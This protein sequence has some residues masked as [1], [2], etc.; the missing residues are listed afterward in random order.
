LS[1]PDR[2]HLHQFTLSS[3]HTHNLLAMLSPSDLHGLADIVA[4]LASLVDTLARWIDQINDFTG[5]NSQFVAEQ[6]LVLAQEQEEAAIA[7]VSH[8]S[9]K[10]PTPSNTKKN[11]LKAP[12]PP[13]KAPA[14]AQACAA[15]LKAHPTPSQPAP[16]NLAQTFPTVNPRVW[17][18]YMFQTT[19]IH[20][21]F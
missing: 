3:L 4:S 10:K 8:S 16:F 12:A 7:A 11:L 1:S 19:N 14:K 21:D 18:F 13:P 6:A 20:V 15:I 9:L 5:Q 17:E 2:H